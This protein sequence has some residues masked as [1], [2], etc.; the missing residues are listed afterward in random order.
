MCCYE[1]NNEARSFGGDD[2][3]G[4]LLPMALI[5][6]TLDLWQFES[7]DID[8]RRQEVHDSAFIF[9]IKYGNTGLLNQRIHNP[10][11]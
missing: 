4:R 7:R 8:E 9:A 10:P 11:V 1:I 3:P 5:A 2:Q 6:D